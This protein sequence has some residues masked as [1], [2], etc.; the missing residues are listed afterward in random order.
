M[1]GQGRRTPPSEKLWVF[2]EA[3]N[4][5]AE[6]VFAWSSSIFVSYLQRGFLVGKPG[7]TSS[8]SSS[9]VGLRSGHLWNWTLDLNLHYTRNH[10]IDKSL[11]CELFVYSRFC[12]HLVK[13]C[14]GSVSHNQKWSNVITQ[15]VH[16]MVQPIQYK[17]DQIKYFQSIDKSNC[18]LQTIM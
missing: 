17:S 1:G 6:Y 5:L 13:Y 15:S 8:D 14:T 4:S 11:L 12:C 16:H 10:S 3:L 18:E 7:S 9:C 2:R